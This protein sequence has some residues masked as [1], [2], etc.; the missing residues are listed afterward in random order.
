MLN[1]ENYNNEIWSIRLKHLA[2]IERR[3]WWV[4]LSLPLGCYFS[5]AFPYFPN[6][7][8][9]THT[10]YTLHNLTTN[11]LLSYY[12]VYFY[13]CNSSSIRTFNRLWEPNAYAAQQRRERCCSQCTVVF[14][15]QSP[16]HA[17]YI[18][19][20]LSGT[21]KRQNHRHRRG[22]QPKHG[23]T[24]HLQQRHSHVA[25]WL[26]NSCHQRHWTGLARLET[27]CTGT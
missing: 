6:L 11:Y 10:F 23:P 27:H 1:G 13:Q 19:F 2:V 20:H 21:G 18:D 22:C 15:I 8:N 26:Q 16:K 7:Y 17:T 24:G 3:C 5:T 14:N 12:H 4:Y 9:N 25:T